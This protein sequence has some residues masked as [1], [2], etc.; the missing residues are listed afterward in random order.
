MKE[1]PLLQ[2]KNIHAS[3]GATKALKGVDFDLYPGEIHAIIGEHRAGKSTLAKLLSGAEK[4]NSGQI[5]LEDAEI[6]YFSPQTSMQHRIGI[7]YQ[8]INIIPA[9]NAVENIFTGQML[10]KRIPV[11]HHQLM[12]KKTRELLEY[13]G[14]KFSLKTAVYNLSPTQQHVVELARALIVNPK[15]L[16]LDEL[17]NKLTPEEMKK[18]YRVLFDLREKGTGIIYISH[19]MDEVLKLAERVTVLKDGYRRS[20]DLSKNLDKYRL[21][22]LTYS[23]KLDQQQLEHTESK[24]FMLSKYLENII[25]SLPIGA[26][27]LDNADRI[28]LL[29]F[30]ST[31]LFQFNTKPVVNKRI[32]DILKDIALPKKKEIL[33]AIEEHTTRTWDEL[34]V[35]DD[36]I[37]KIHLFPLEDENQVFLGTAIFVEDI[38]L[39]TFMTDYLIQSEKMASIAE[40]AVGVAHE[41][42]NPLYI[43]RNYL[44][45]IKSKTGEPNLQEKILKIEKELGRIVDIVTNL[46]SF[47][48]IKQNVGKEVELNTVIEEITVLLQHN[49][50]EKQIK[51]S[52]KLP[53]YPI[54][55]QGDENRLKQVFINL[56][57]NSIDAV[58]SNGKIELKAEYQDEKVHVFIADNGYGIPED[59]QDKIFKPFFTTKITKKNTGLGLSVCSHIINEHGGDITFSSIPGE[60]TVFTLQLPAAASSSRVAVKEPV[61]K[62]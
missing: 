21:F 16:I 10:K 26:V 61:K 9:L 47:S 45:L 53:G 50:S 4:K 25:H 54:Y 42:N 11:L 3:Y 17:S 48:R 51:L 40:V 5:V 37:L 29:N 15:I 8:N 20:T 24:F 14:F 23:F 27:I 2:M 38:S 34:E 32:Q 56:F 41:I 18:V 12:I 35:T 39:N 7:V 58:L 59:V 55:V 52:K 44:E 46:L 43:I 19:D 33:Q 22:Q 31:E 13:I 30:T 28:R 60:K 49:I 62:G 1:S 6:D 36:L 57:M